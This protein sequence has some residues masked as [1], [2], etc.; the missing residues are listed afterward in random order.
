[1]TTQNA[2]NGVSFSRGKDYRVRRV[3]MNGCHNVT[4]L[5]LYS[6]PKGSD[7][8]LVNHSIMCQVDARATCVVEIMLHDGKVVAGEDGSDA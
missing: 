3:V 7:L 2:S 5:P 1:M 6:S 8:R 4:R